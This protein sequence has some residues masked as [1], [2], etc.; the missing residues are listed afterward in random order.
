MRNIIL[1]FH[2]PGYLNFYFR[3][4]RPSLKNPDQ[5]NFMNNIDRRISSM[6]EVTKY[7][8]FNRME[9]DSCLKEELILWLLR[10]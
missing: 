7:L 6:A 2:N 5:N 4:L 1:Y 3:P 8:T 9:K 10:L